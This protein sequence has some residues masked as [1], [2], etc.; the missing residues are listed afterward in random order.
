MRP[1]V[2]FSLSLAVPRMQRFHDITSH[3]FFSAPD[4]VRMN[5][6]AEGKYI[7]AAI[8]LALVMSA[9]GLTRFFHHVPNRYQSICHPVP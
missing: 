6:I 3:M 2:K 4:C 1:S 8:V 7:T 5:V 9:L